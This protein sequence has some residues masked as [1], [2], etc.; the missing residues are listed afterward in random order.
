MPG[1]PGLLL[2]RAVNTTPLLEISVETL[3]AARAAERGGADRIE[4][5]AATSVGGLTPSGTTMRGARARLGIPIFV[6]IRPRSGD[7]VYSAEEFATM[8]AQ[9]REAR[10]LGV[11]G[12]GRGILTSAGQ[13]DVG[14][15]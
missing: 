1:A 4:L 13:G 2:Y 3:E 14:T 15:S 5:C 9:I 11:D 10:E 12:L 7:F 6:M 8:R